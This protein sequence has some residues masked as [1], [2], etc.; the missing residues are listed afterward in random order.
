MKRAWN[1]CATTAAVLALS[2]SVII[3]AASDQKAAS[4][5]GRPSKYIGCLRGEYGS[6][7]LTE[8]GGPDVPETRNWRTL[9]LTKM[10]VLQVMPSGRMDLQP[11]VGTTVR[12]TGE[13]DG[14]TLHARSVTHV[15]ATCK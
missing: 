12:I 13:R 3:A 4:D 11:H 7:E 6:F 2:G 15:G 9:Y 8:V 10:R 5:D 1:V 14:N